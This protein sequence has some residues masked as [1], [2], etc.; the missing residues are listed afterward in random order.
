MYGGLDKADGEYGGTKGRRWKLDW[1]QAP[2]PIQIKLKTL[3]GVRDKLPG[4]LVCIT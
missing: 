2:Q 1:D 3:R 4:M